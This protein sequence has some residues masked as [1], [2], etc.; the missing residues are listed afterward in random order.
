V[1]YIDGTVLL[2]QEQ[3]VLQGMVGR[4]TDTGRCH[5]MEINVDK[6]VVIRISRQPFPAQI[7]TNQKQTRN[8]EYINWFGSIKTNDARCTREIKSRFTIAEAAFKKQN[9]LS[10]A[11]WTKI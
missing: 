8:V 6:A 4:L 9:V 7:M 10:P 3:T 2:L 5:G 1:K 11:K